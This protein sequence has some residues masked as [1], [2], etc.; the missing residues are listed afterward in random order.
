M[1]KNIIYNGPPGTGKTFTA[2]KKAV[3]IVAGLSEHERQS[4]EEVDYEELY[5]QYAETGQIQLCTFHQSFSYEEFI[6]GIRMDQDNRFTPED[7]IFKQISRLA[8]DAYKKYNER[9]FVQMPLGK[10]NE[11]GG[12][13]ILEYGIKN[14]IVSTNICSNIADEAAYKANY[15]AYDTIDKIEGMLEEN[16]NSYAPSLHL[17]KNELKPG[18]II[19]ISFHKDT[20]NAIAKVVGPYEYIANPSKQHFKHT[21]QVEWLSTETMQVKDFYKYEVLNDNANF[22]LSELYRQDFKQEHALFQLIEP[23]EKYVLIIDEINRGNIA[24]IFGELISLIE[25]SKRLGAAEAMHVTLPYSKEPFTVPNNLYIIGTMNTTDRSIA[26]MDAALR[27]RFT[28]YEVMPQANIL[29]K[30]QAQSATSME[31]NLAK[32][33]T[34]MNQRIA[35]LY[36][37]EHMIGHA[38]FMD[39]VTDQDVVDVF[40]SRIIPLLQEYFYDDWRQLELILGGAATDRQDTNYFLYKEDIYPED[41]FNDAYQGEL[42]IK[43][44]YTLIKQPSTNALSHIYQAGESYATS[45]R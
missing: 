23:L 34:T 4:E 8:E 2:R 25:P 15:A 40:T 37:R 39:C 31:V 7:G 41:I 6:E 9:R 3:Q 30:L 28:Y 32:L 13:P 38:Y 1:E 26:L 11:D 24:Q 12:N 27:R 16:R 45:H 20:I 22:L 18:D 21:R 35:F 14:N 17:F 33:L 29:K 44:T 5:E 36:D 19:F 43:T 42:Q 10:P